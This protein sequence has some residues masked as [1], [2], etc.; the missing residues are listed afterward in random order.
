MTCDRC[1]KIN[2]IPRC[3]DS[4]EFLLEGLSFPD[5]TSEDLTAIFR[6]VA[7]DRET[8]IGFDVDIDGDPLIDLFEVY[9]LGGHPYEIKFIDSEGVPVQFTLTNPNDTTEQ[10]CCIEF[11]TLPK[12]VVGTDFWRLSTTTCQV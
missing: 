9:P 3:I 8:P 2:R 12:D 6:D 10:G 11:E 5:N 4:E 7:T 1:V